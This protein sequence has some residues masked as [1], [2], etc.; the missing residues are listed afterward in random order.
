[1]D[2]TVAKWT[3]AQ[4]IDWLI[5]HGQIYPDR[6]GLRDWSHQDLVNA[7]CSIMEA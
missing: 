4:L 6:A 1:M 7:A 5:A 2:P 3:K